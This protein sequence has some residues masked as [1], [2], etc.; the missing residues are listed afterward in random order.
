MLLGNAKMSTSGVDNLR[1]EGAAS[2]GHLPDGCVARFYQ[3]GDEVRML[4]LLDASFRR[5][6]AVEIPGDRLK[7]LQWKLRSTPDATRYH[8]VA[9]LESKIIACRPYLLSKF[10][11]CGEL[12]SVRQGVDNA[13]HPDYR[14]GGLMTALMYPPPARLMNFEVYFG[15][16]SGAEAFKVMMRHEE[17]QSCDLGVDVMEISGRLAED[18]VA[19]AHSWP[20]AAWSISSVTKFDERIEAL[21]EEASR[22]FRFIVHRTREYLNWRYADERAGSFTIRLVEE[23]DRL[24]GFSALRI[25][26]DR[27]YIADLLVL[28]GRTDVADAL[29]RDALVHVREHGVA[30]LQ[31]W[32]TPGHPYRTSFERLGF[33]KKARKTV[34]IQPLRLAD[35]RL[36]RFVSAKTPTHVTIGDTDLI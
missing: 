31:G 17:R 19:K 34:Y 14:G 15:I 16:R 12:V 24:L 27:G 8:V 22:P 20:P 21:C 4:E 1:E 5:W 18:A 30:S 2:L 9:E 35:E 32:A 6:P 10:R 7:H 29:A 11:L 36:T 25:G 33:R 28:P 23:G 13:V 26:G 3:P